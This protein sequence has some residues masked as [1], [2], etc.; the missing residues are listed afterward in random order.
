MDSVNPKLPTSDI[1]GVEQASLVAAEANPPLKQNWN[2]NE[3]HGRYGFEDYEG[4]ETV[5]VEHETLK[6]GDICP[7]CELGKVYR[8]EAGRF[9]RLEGTPMVS[10]KR[11][12]LNGLRCNLCLTIFKPSV[13]EAIKEAPK[14]APSAISSLAIG[15][16]YYGQPFN[17]IEHWQRNCKIPL[18]DSTQYDEMVK[19]SLKVKPIVRCLERLSANA[20]LMHYDDTPLKILADAGGHGTAIVSQNGEHWIYLFYVSNRVAGKEVSGLLKLRDS[21]AP[22]TTMTDALRHNEL[23]DV[24]EVLLSKLIVSFCLVHG[25]RKFF[26]LLEDFPAECKLVVDCIAEIYGHEA[27]CKAMNLSPAERL[28]YHQTHSAKLLDALKIYLSNLW[29]YEGVEHNST[30]GDA[31][32][33]MLKRWSG[34]T[35]FLTV[36]GCPLDNTLCE[37]A[38][39]VLI[40]YR[41]NSL[42]YRSVK[43]GLCGNTLMSLIHTAMQNNIN[44]FDYLNAIQVHQDLVQI[45][46]EAF[47]PWNYQTTLEGL[48]EQELKI[49]A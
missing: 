8:Y 30:L 33:Y 11:Y 29:Q 34:L 7:D 37:R 38:I 1:T 20:S 40:R 3:N 42:F 45:T 41:K 25:R 5:V 31:V 22:L 49:A 36:E 13:P 16:Y 10:G 14:F 35:R 39:K 26:D 17:R 24:D 32:Q 4:L 28:T 12:Q 9:I 6:S 2:K 21:D 46:P 47:L 15:H 18:P 27:H 43:G 44:A 23:T 19:L 48:K